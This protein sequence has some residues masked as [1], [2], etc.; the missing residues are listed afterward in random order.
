MDDD[1][2]IAPEP[3]AV[4]VRPRRHWR[5]YV[6]GVPLALLALL[7][8]A[9]LVLD[10]PIGHRFI[11]D[12]LASY[13]PASGLRIEVGRIEGSLSNRA[14]LRNVT[15]ADPQGIFLR[16]PEARL[17]WRPLHWFT[18][19][20]DVRELTLQRGSLSRLPRLKPG[21]PDAPILP[22]FDIRI[23]RL[24]IENLTIEQGALGKG[25]AGKPRRV[26]LNGKADIRKGRALVRLD[27]RLGGEDR[28]FAM[29]DAEPDRDRFDLKLDYAA[30]R[31]GLLAGLTG[32]D[33]N[34][35]ARIAG[36]GGWRHWQGALLADQD[37]TRLAALQLTNTAGRYAALG[38]VWPADLLTG[39]A[40][41]ASGDVV[42]VSLIGTLKNSV[43]SGSLFA[44]GQGLRLD[45]AGPVDLAGNAFAATR[46]QATLRDPALLGGNTQLEGAVLAAVLDGPFRAM[47][48]QHSLKAASLSAGTVRLEGTATQGMASLADGVWH[49]PLDLAVQ[50]LVT[51]TA[52]VDPRLVDLHLRGELQLDGTRLTG[53]RLALTL[54]G[55]EAQLTLRGDMARGGYGLAGNAA[56]RG[57]PLANVGLADARGTVLASFGNAPWKVRTDL[58]GS[59]ARVDNETLATVA[60]APIRFAGVLALGQGQPLLIERAT[61]NGRKL[62]LTLSGRR[63]PDGRTTL[64]GRG[65]HADYGPFTIETQIDGAGPRATLV[66]ADPLPAAGLKDVRVALAPIPE[67]FRIETAGQSTLGPF[68]GTLGLYARRGGPTRIAIETLKVWQTT[69][70]GSLALAA[71][72]VDGT[73]LLNGGGVY[74]T[75]KLAPRGGGQ[76]FDVGLVAEDARFAGEV[77]LTIADGRLE[78]SGSLVK[79]HSTVTI[80]AFGQGIGRGS[81]FLGRIAANGSMTDGTGRFTAALAGRRGSRFDLQVL[82]DLAPGRIALH[83]NGEF[84]GQRITMPRRAVLTAEEDGWRLAPSQLDFGGGRVIA[85]G[86]I[87]SRSTELDIAM[88][89]MPLSLADVA[90]AD[91]GLGGKASGLVEYRGRHGGLPSGSARVQVK[92]LTRSGL[93]LTSRPVDLALV[94]TLTAQ[95][96]ETRAVVRE[97]GQVR[98]RVQGRI[99][100]LPASGTLA[101]RLRAGSLFGQLRYDGPADALWRLVALDAFDLTGPVALA[102]DVTG[103]IENPAIHGSLASDAMRLQSAVIGTDITG[104]AARGRFAGSRLE[105]TSLSGRAANG[106]QV[107]G[108]GTIDLAG[109]G[110]HGPVID[111]RLAARNALV[112]S[113]SDMAAAV[114][115]PMRIVSDGHAGTI[116]GRVAIDTARWQLGRAAAIEQLPA[117]RTREINRRAD[118]APPRAAMAPWRFL[119]DAHGANRVDVRGLGLDSEWS[120]DV[121]I[122]GTT[123]APAIQG[124]ADLVRGGYEFAGRRFELQH[125]HILF[126]GSSPPNPRLDIA[127]E[128]SVTGLTARVLVGGTSYKPEITFTSTP[129]MP[130]EEVLSRLLFG[131]SITQISAPEA[132]QLA[133]ALGSLR[134]GGGLDPINKLRSAIGLDRL[135]IVSADVATGR[136]TG[137][138]AGKYLG[139][140]VYAEVV[141]DGHGYSATD[142]EFRVTNWLSI[143]G[144][145]STIGRQS[146]NA[147]VSKDY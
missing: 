138:A 57:W 85:S 87:A 11:A 28:L 105:L 54:P 12:R 61:L 32:L 81:L 83:G 49:L 79:G 122:R 143:L 25:E 139:R 132:L 111:L 89:D 125:G 144:S 124:R 45:A 95:A 129:A 73:L 103:S 116:A 119:I 35:R 75:V 48:A 52:A 130:E 71:N 50:R 98:G 29:L 58:T 109:I 37:G 41:R 128:A 33:R 46:V 86:L 133:S 55:G 126:D 74:G 5:R 146:V 42:A 10:S 121:R 123:A 67:G 14:T 91:L 2:E 76:G 77:P 108:S 70:T 22:N 99:S 59:L 142:L 36:A 21:N 114:T 134:G 8:L 107:G 9:L 23:D 96:L 24:A 93:V 112:I 106:G 135:R 84:A 1:A 66:F 127:A 115:G 78:A 80:K 88:A 38:Q 15:F 92:G 145:V 53:D 136:G 82:G 68:T 17:D 63:L 40:K 18:S 118:I 4:P 7:A 131:S 69:V 56:L 39:L 20:L 120:A 60:G 26:D 65:A 100:A 27:G 43:L 16:V 141:S 113:R 31:G 51:G 104:I 3:E 6:L 97:G 64:A 13:A 62:N 94:G 72:G 34:L 19:G 47:T 102:A 90:I 30:P 110:E 117:I 147:K 101:E 137:V 140:R 44:Q